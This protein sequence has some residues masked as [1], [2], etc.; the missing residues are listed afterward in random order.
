MLEFI[1]ERDPSNAKSVKKT[2]FQTWN[3]IIHTVDKPF[4]CRVCAKRFTASDSLRWHAKIHSGEKQFLCQVCQKAFS[5]HSSLKH[6]EKLTLLYKP[7][8]SSL[9]KNISQ[10]PQVKN[11]VGILP[12][13]SHLNCS[14]AK[15][16]IQASLFC[17]YGK[18]PYC[19]FFQTKIFMVELI[20]VRYSLPSMP[21]KSEIMSRNLLIWK[22]TWDSILERKYNFSRS[23]TL[24]FH[25]KHENSYW[26]EA[27]R[28]KRILSDLHVDSV[29]LE[30]ILKVNPT[31]ASYVRFNRDTV[32]I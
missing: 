25:D 24:S 17:R 20:L 16:H 18:E 22:L 23:H 1:R 6:H 3:A 13:E 10:L 28:S 21:V 15:E 9:L 19:L 5:L 14:F 26:R 8:A 11:H 29:M 27:C 12:R 30:F 32:V 2:F 31:S 4:Q 7:F